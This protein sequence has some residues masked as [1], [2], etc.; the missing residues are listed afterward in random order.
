V[1][2]EIMFLGTAGSAP[3]AARAPSATILRREGDLLLV[4]CGEGTQRQLLRSTLGLTEI[5]VIVL[6]HYHA[7]HVLGLPG[8]LKTYDLHS[9][10]HPL[11]LVGPPGLRELM[12][13]LSPFVGRL[14]FELVTR[15]VGDGEA[16]ERDGYRLVPRAVRHRGHA[17]AWGLV[18]A[19]RPGVF[20]A[21]LASELGVP[22]GP[23]RAVLLRGEPVTLAD[24]RTITPEELVGPARRGRSVVL[25]GDT[26]PCNS[27]VELASGADVLVHE[28]TFT[29]DGS[30]RAAETQHTTAGGAALVAREAGV[31][32]LALTHLGQRTSP[33][34]AEAEAR[35][36]FPDTFVPRD[37]DI[38]VVPL[39]ERGSPRLEPR[40]AR[41]GRPGA[42]PPEVPDDAPR[43]VLP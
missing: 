28:A 36:V 7:D 38:I 5:D 42:A 34:E 3:S 33:R 8:L 17:L 18:E 39:P 16:V 41:R 35:E 10:V 4:D 15:E 30:D 19:G 27:V 26:V 37:F 40:A 32:L 43:E 11:E 24:G 29:A 12:R 20:D 6:T 1:D 13:I 25:S 21:D 22:H 31:H 2:I 14:G 9:R 23:E